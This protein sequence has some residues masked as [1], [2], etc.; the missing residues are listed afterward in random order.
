MIT[1]SVNSH[2]LLNTFCIIYQIMSRI[3]YFYAFLHRHW[4]SWGWSC[5][6]EFL[7]NGAGIVDEKDEL[8]QGLEFHIFGNLSGV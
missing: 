3:F 7:E 6:C 4:T 1:S 5:I 2:Y 8:D